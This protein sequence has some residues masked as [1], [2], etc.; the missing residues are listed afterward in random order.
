MPILVVVIVVVVEAVVDGP[1]SGLL[2]SQ[3]QFCPQKLKLVPAA[4]G[5]VMTSAPYW[6]E[7]YVLQVGSL[8]S[9]MKMWVE[10]GAQGWLLVVADIAVVMAAEVVV[11]VVVEGVVVVMV[12]V[13]VVVGLVVVVVVVMVVVGVVIVVDIVVVVVVVVPPLLYI[14]I[15]QSP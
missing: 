10:W 15:L 5:Y 1:R 8:G 13:V 7:R 9:A 6:Q 11:V 14:S 12:V 2:P 4:Q 3:S